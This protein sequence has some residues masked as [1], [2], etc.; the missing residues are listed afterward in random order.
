[1][2]EISKTLRVASRGYPGERLH[3]QD[4]AFIADRAPLSG[5][6]GSHDQPLNLIMVL[7]AELTGLKVA[8][9]TR[10][11]YGRRLAGALASTIGVAQPTSFPLRHQG[12]VIMR[13]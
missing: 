8:H 11:R 1:V 12:L 4:D 10:F 2:Q 7:A 9:A 5:R 13:A 6:V 3:V